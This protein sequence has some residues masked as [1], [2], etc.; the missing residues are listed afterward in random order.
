MV[1]SKTK[2]LIVEDERDI[3]ELI[4]YNLER[5]GFQVETA[6]SGEEGLDKTKK[7]HPDLVVL[8]I[9]LPEMNGLDV[10]RALRLDQATRSIP[11]I[12]L[13]ARNEDIDVV[14]GL[15]VGA[16]DYITKP[17]SPRVLI[18]RIRSVLRRYKES[19]ESKSE[20]LQ[21]GELTIDCGKRRVTVSGSPVELT[22]TE[23]ELL[24]VLAGRP[25]WVF[26]RIQLIDSLRDGQ[27]VI[28]NRA[29]DV[30]VA[31][32]RKKLTVCGHYIQTVRGVG[33]RMT[34]TP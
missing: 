24:F 26:S 4:V 34:E 28:T 19:V 18:A 22:H 29:I 3:A 25:G 33:Y 12:M 11:I 1:S 15:E 21:F 2:I 8:D 9:M 30:Q 5:E 32:L 10:C 17:F 7:E 27:L 14:T 31:N 20:F 13:T 16:D 23:F 6:V